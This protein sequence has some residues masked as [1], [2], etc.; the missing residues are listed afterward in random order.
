MLEKA[1]PTVVE[2]VPAAVKVA[3]KFAAGD[4]AAVAARMDEFVQPLS[5][6]S[7]EAFQSM[8]SLIA[9]GAKGLKPIEGN[10][11]SGSVGVLNDSIVAH[12][13]FHSTIQQ[14]GDHIR[15]LAHDGARL[16]LTP[17][18]MKMELIDGT[19]INQ[20][21][22]AISTKLP[23]GDIVRQQW[24]GDDH[25]VTTLNGKELLDRAGR[26]LPDGAHMSNSERHAASIFL[27][28]GTY[29]GNNS[30]GISVYRGVNPA[31]HWAGGQA[32]ITI[33]TRYRSG[34][35]GLTLHNSAEENMFSSSF[36]SATAKHG[37][38]AQAGRAFKWLSDLVKG[39]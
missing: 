11:M 9:D 4:Y 2:D 32:P 29:L 14:T 21:G 27:K 5:R 20:E 22:R 33:E 31:S 38:S 7:E 13:P 24:V 30:Y 23:G 19:I 18:S 28:D 8:R 15:L 1:I 25:V 12:F 16:E 6:L 10:Q 36:L 17:N 3:E 39:S 34:V 37:A 26:S 35:P